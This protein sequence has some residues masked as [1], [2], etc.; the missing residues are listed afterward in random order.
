M[1]TA[2]AIQG[3]TLRRDAWWVEI[4]PTILLLGGFAIYSTWAALVN[5]DFFVEPYVSPFYS[6]CL[7]VNCGDAAVFR[8]FGAWWT[9]TPALFI[10]WAP[11]GFRA[12]CY[13]YRKSYYRAFF[14]SPPACAVKDAAAKYSGETRFPFI[15][16]NLHRY[17]FWA[18]WPILGFLW[19]DAVKAFDFED[20]LGLGIGTLV[21][22]INATLLTLYS[23]SCHSGRHLLGGHVDVFSKAPLR[24]RAWRAISRL[25]ERHGAIAWVSLVW[26][27]LTDVYVRLLA[28]GTISQ[29]TDRIF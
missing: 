25:N 23:L 26:V 2:E 20:G 3:K 18:V 29:S 1:Q 15:L 10:L 8:I 21:L 24:H 4:L 6:P 14:G 7:A 5:R 12:T 9:I 13:Y 22:I 28:N 11:L 19:Y 17:F 27:A 16:Q